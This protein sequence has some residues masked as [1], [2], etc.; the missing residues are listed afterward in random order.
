[1][2]VSFVRRERTPNAPAFCAR[3]QGACR[4]DRAEAEA[5][6]PA[7]AAPRLCEPFV[8]ERR[9]SAIG[10]DAA[11]ARGYFD[12]ADL[13]ARAGGAPQELG[14]RSTSVGRNMSPRQIYP[15]VS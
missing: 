6:Q 8:A 12:H 2:A 9:R 13:H 3:P 10:A 5:G 7:R 4:R 14:T 15:P 11:R 1:M